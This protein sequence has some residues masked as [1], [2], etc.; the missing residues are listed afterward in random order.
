MKN[1]S[2]EEVYKEVPGTIAIGVV[3]GI[4]GVVLLKK[5]NKKRKY[6]SQYLSMHISK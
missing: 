4:L 1:I 5:K 6:V 3:A 2:S